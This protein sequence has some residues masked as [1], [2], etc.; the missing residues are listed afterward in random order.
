MKTTSDSYFDLKSDSNY[1]NEHLSKP[2][3]KMSHHKE[4]ISDERQHK[5]LKEDK[6][7]L[8]NKKDEKKDSTRDSEMD[9]NKNSTEKSKINPYRDTSMETD[10][11]SRR[12]QNKDTTRESEMDVYKDDARENKMDLHKDS[13]QVSKTDT[14]NRRDEKKDYFST[15]AKRFNENPRG[16]RDDIEEYFRKVDEK[17]KKKEEEH[18]KK[19]IEEDV[20]EVL[21]KVSKYDM[22]YKEKVS[23]WDVFSRDGKSKWDIPPKVEPP[24]QPVKN[25]EKD[26][27]EDDKKL[28]SIYRDTRQPVLDMFA[29]EL[30]NNDIHSI[31]QQAYSDNKVRQS[32]KFIKA[33]QQSH[34]SNRKED[35][36]ESTQ[37]QDGTQ[38]YL[39]MKKTPPEEQKSNRESSGRIRRRFTDEPV[40]RSEQSVHKSES[41]DKMNLSKQKSNYQFQEKVDDN[42]QVY[43]SNKRTVLPP[44]EEK[45]QEDTRTVFVGKNK[46]ISSSQLTQNLPPHTTES[47]SESS[48][49]ECSR[50]RRQ[51]LDA[52]KPSTDSRT[53]VPQTRTECSL[54][55]QS[56]SQSYFTSHKRSW[57]RSP[58][59]DS[60]SSSSSSG[61]MSVIKG[62]K[63]LPRLERED[64]W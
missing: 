44:T 2:D 7:D 26:G 43:M 38:S 41:C 58:S 39:S 46:H 45:K 53:V 34:Q 51:L 48:D 50:L 35:A 64:R 1:E 15:S 16:Q 27:K 62:T 3:K 14:S 17:N 52:R 19:K 60:N 18:G 57:R 9:M 4:N 30:Q 21:K 56:Y 59:A 55:E 61:V 40:T 29:E 5:S 37:G 23:Q 54:T 13:T 11:S 31:I 20:S 22:T 63:R 36:Q 12:D 49:S 47:G 42:R 10:F 33:S 8:Y 25:I 32:N 24:K 28:A 6:T